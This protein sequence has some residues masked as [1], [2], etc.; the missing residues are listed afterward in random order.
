M[1]TT[2]RIKKQIDTGAGAKE[3]CKIKYV[4]SNT[5]IGLPIC[6]A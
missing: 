1:L 4:P 2:T 6:T 5:Q 3:T